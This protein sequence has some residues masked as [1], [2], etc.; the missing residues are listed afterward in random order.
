[1]WKP[2]PFTNWNVPPWAIVALR[3][4]KSLNAQLCPAGTAAALSAAI[5][6]RGVTGA[7][8]AAPP[9]VSSRPPTSAT[10]DP[11]TPLFTIA[12]DNA[13][14][15]PAGHN[16]AF[17]DFFPR[18][19]TIAQGGT[20]QFVNGGGFHTAT[21]L[22]LSW[23]TPVRTADMDVNGIAAADLDDTSANPNGTTHVLENIAPLLPVQPAKDCGTADAPS[24]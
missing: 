19:A 17:N 12:A 11:A 18:S 20:F 23:T 15:V 4:K 2:P 6:K 10:A 22:P 16:W 24:P 3:G 13:A 7:A 21:L 9:V 1:M 14:A 8:A 5:V